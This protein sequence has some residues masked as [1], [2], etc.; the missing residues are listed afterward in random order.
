MIDKMLNAR[1]FKS[2]KLFCHGNA[3]SCSERD[4]ITGEWCIWEHVS[5]SWVAQ[6]PPLP[7]FQHCQR[8]AW[9]GDRVVL[10]LD[11]WECGGRG[12]R[13]RETVVGEYWGTG[14]V[15][16]EPTWICGG[17]DIGGSGGSFCS[18][19]TLKHMEPSQQKGNPENA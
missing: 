8:Q 5:V 3:F 9:V 6:T 15:S 14:I 11:L 2:G 19:K 17:G 4:I 18:N 13:G 1:F 16:R 7:S 12:G 10:N